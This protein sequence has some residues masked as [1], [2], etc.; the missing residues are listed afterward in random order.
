MKH[1]A[2]SWILWIAFG[3]LVAVAPAHA[4]EPAGKKAAAGLDAGEMTDGWL[5]LGRR[6]E[7]R[8]RPAS[9]SISGPRYPVKSGQKVVVRRDALVYGSVDCKVTDAA[10]FKADKVS[11]SVVLVKADRRG[12]EI[13]GTPIECP[14]VGQAKTVWA[15]VRIPATR[16]VSVERQ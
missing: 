3:L 6:S 8:W 4:A 5:Y 13:F 14:S 7:D 15:S 9:R 12:L 2:V 11:G 10:E 1:R 16:L